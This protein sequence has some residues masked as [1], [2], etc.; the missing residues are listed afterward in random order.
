MSAAA[1]IG[2]VT[3]A[4]GRDLARRRAALLLLTLLPLAFYAALAGHSNHAVVTTTV[5]FA[6]S[7]GGAAIFS[8]LAAADVDRRLV[9]AGYR[10]FE[11]LAGRLAVLLATSLPIAVLGAVVMTSVSH[12]GRPA[13]LFGAVVL[14]AA[15]AVPF[16]LAVGAVVR[17]ELEATLILIGVV[18]IQLSV[19]PTSRLS[20]ALPFGQP[21]R[22]ALASVSGSAHPLTVV[23]LSLGYAA[24]LLLVAALIN[25]ARLG[26]IRPRGSCR[27][28][29]LTVGS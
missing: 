6:F 18:G 19:E 20:G 10:P 22:L 8:S 24:G 16:G 27:V 3:E 25:H 12:P 9:L 23:G 5:A 11:L 15:I 13:Y 14:S 1:R 4:H 17:R 21:R 26:Q 29:D 28:G 7:G 2:A